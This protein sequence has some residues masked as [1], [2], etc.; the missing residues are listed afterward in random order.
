MSCVYV[1]IPYH[2]KQVI[3]SLNAA[4]SKLVEFEE[5]HDSGGD[6]GGSASS[7]AL[8]VGGEDITAEE[9]GDQLMQ[10]S[11]SWNN[12]LRGIGDPSA[13]SREERNF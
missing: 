7:S 1:S 5:K 10:L 9:G 13:L 3:K 2:T 8:V 6:S 4:D 11:R 12:L